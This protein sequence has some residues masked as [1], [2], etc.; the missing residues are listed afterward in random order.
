MDNLSD[1]DLLRRLQTGSEAAL[2]ALHERYVAAVYAV[3]YRVLH[4]QMLAEEVTQDTFLRLWEHGHTYDP[5]RG[6]F[7]P[8]LLTITRRRAID[9][10][11]QRQRREPAQLETFSLDEHPYLWEQFGQSDEQGELR[12]TLFDALAGLPEEQREAIALAYFYGLSHGEI[13]ER[14]GV[15]L[16]TIKTRIR[17]G[18]RKLRAAWFGAEPPSGNPVDDFDA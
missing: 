13:A 3:A 10:L 12:H 17:L 11:R 1:I 5:A 14:L 15:P 2:L 8:W 7:L 18:M 6:A 16:G 9:I 4:E